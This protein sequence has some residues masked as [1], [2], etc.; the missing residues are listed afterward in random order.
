VRRLTKLKDASEVFI[1]TLFP[2]VYDDVLRLLKRGVR[3]YLLKDARILKKLRL[4]NNLR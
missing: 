3:V 1:D 4:E 2:E